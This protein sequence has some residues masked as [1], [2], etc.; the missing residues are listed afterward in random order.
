MVNKVNAVNQ[1]TLIVPEPEVVVRIE[2]PETKGVQN[3]ISEPSKE[4]E[5]QVAPKT[6]SSVESHQNIQLR[7]WL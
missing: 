3:Q 6:G 7:V 5:V 2:I 1:E 4:V